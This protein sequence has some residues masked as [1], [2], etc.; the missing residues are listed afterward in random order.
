MVRNSVRTCRRA[1]LAATMIL[2]AAAWLTVSSCRGVLGVEEPVLIQ[3]A[4]GEDASFPEAGADQASED[5]TVAETSDSDAGA[6]DVSNE[7]TPQDGSL[8]QDAGAVLHE[9]K[10]SFVLP[11]HIQLAE[12]VFPGWDF[13]RVLAEAVP[14]RNAAAIFIERENMNSTSLEVLTVGPTEPMQKQ[15]IYL[16]QYAHLWDALAHTGQPNT[17]TLLAEQLNFDNNHIEVVQ[18]EI[19][20][21]FP[22]AE[23]G[24]PVN[25]LDVGFDTRV[26]SLKATRDGETI[27]AA[28]S[29]QPTGGT[30]YSTLLPFGQLASSASQE[31]VEVTGIVRSGTTTYVFLHGGTGGPELYTVSDSASPSPPHLFA[32]PGVELV[33]VANSPSGGVNVAIRN[34]VTQTL[35]VGRLPV[36]SLGTF[37]HNQLLA[38]SY[39]NVSLPAGEGRWIGDDLVFAGPTDDPLSI[40]ILWLDLLGRFRVQGKVGPGLGSN[41][42]TAMVRAQNVTST[43]ADLHLVWTEWA[44]PEAGDPFEQLMYNQ[45]R[46]ESSD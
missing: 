28:V 26:R 44:T 20:E 37:T 19:P 27:K 29:A 4:G 3:A 1:P 23:A 32:E 12:G 2:G 17:T 6:H 39:A 11:T 42:K 10:C 30:Y 36:N 8:D 43:S 14:I 13:E 45:I 41:I 24:A 7:P 31:E 38:V 9:M 16:S 15:N 40:S 34:A 21:D 25:P 46:C 33:A 18:V 5:G 22:A 35:F